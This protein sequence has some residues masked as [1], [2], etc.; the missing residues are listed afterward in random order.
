MRRPAGRLEAHLVTEPAAWKASPA[1]AGEE[2][3]PLAARLRQA[4]ALLGPPLGR[5]MYSSNNQMP[6]GGEKVVRHLLPDVTCFPYHTS[7]DLIVDG[8]LEAAG[9]PLAVSCSAANKSLYGLARALGSP[10]ALELT[11]QHVV[12]RPRS[13][14]GAELGVYLESGGAGRRRPATGDGGGEPAGDDG[15]AGGWSGGGGGGAAAA[16]A[17][18][19]APRGLPHVRARHSAAAASG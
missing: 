1:A 3:L 2:D 9:V 10:R 7:A 12:R 8:V 11:L 13:S 6:L 5:A 17:A 14:G 4:R 15:S 19:A 18:A 16:A